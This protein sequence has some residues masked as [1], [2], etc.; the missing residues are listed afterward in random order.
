MQML[1]MWD[2]CKD[3]GS[4][5]C[6]WVQIKEE[7]K[8][9]GSIET[10]S[11]LLRVKMGKLTIVSAALKLTYANLQSDKTVFRLI[12]KCIFRNNNK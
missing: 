9:T 3:R 5:I 10:C 11:L 7:S 12:Y 1:A 8:K 6:L 4:T 2:G